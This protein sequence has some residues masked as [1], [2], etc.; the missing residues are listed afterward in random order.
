MQRSKQVSQTRDY[1]NTDIDSRRVLVALA[2]LV[3]TFFW[4][5]QSILTRGFWLNNLFRPYLPDWALLAIALT[6]PISLGLAGLRSVPWKVSVFFAFVGLLQGSLFGLVG[7]R[8]RWVQ[9]GVT[10][11][12]YLEAY[13]F[14]P[15]LNRYFE[16]R[17]IPKDGTVLHLK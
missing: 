17:A 12:A 14:L 5:V 8:Y 13:F 10:L 16:E 7:E 6:A 15:K 2:L 4:I 11:F 1:H 9:G 3:F